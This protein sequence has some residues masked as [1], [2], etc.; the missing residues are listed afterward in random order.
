MSISE[1]DTAARVAACF[2]ADGGRTLATLSRAV[3]DIAL[4]ED[5]LQDAYLAALQRWPRDGFPARPSAWILATARNRAIDRLRRERIGREKLQRLAALE[6]SHAHAPSSEAHDNEANG[7]VPDDRLSLIFA[8]CHPALGIEARIALTLRTLAGLTVEE[9]ADAFLVPHATMAQRLVRVKRKIRETAIPFDVPPA[10]RLAERLADV[11]AVLYLIFNEGYA[12]SSGD[13]LVRRELCDEAIRLARVLLSLMPDEPEVMGLLALMLYHDSRRE[14]RVRAD[15]TLVA[16][17]DQDRT[18]WNRAEIDEATAVLARANRRGAPGPYQLQ[19]MIAFAHASA[20]SADAVDWHGIAELYDHLNR[21][22]PSPVVAL[23]RAI[24]I[25]FA[26][27]PAA[28]LSALDALAGE[29]LAS[30]H[31]Y[32]VARADALARLERTAEAHDA[33]CAALALTQNEAEQA[34]LRAKLRATAYTAG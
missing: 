25:G 13:R 20:A 33:Y 16:L 21:V 17:P 8:C 11:C 32:H 1:A 9:I 4:A 5:A 28:A 2:R 7:A 27:G 10:E 30:Y 3:G 26:D 19:A 6:P 34:Y 18:S 23:N 22:A 29:P 12:A 24:A 31:L 14:A 15:G